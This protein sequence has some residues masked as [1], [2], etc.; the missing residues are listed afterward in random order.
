[1]IRLRSALLVAL[2]ALLAAPSARAELLWRTIN[3]QFPR[4]TYELRFALVLPDDFDPAKTHP[5]MLA[6]PP[7]RG[8]E[9]LVK[10][11]LFYWREGAER[12]GWVVVSPMWVN[13]RP[14]YEQG[15]VV[16]PALV[17]W[18][19]DTFRVEGGKP[20]LTGVSLG[21]VAAFIAAVEYTDLFASLTV[22]PGGLPREHADKVENLARLPTTFY[23]GERDE[24]YMPAAEQLEQAYNAMG[25]VFEKIVIPGHAH[26][27]RTLEDG[28]R[29]YANLDKRRIGRREIPEEIAAASETLTRLHN[30]AAEADE[31]TYFSLFSPA[32]VFL[33]S[34]PAERW[35]I[36][37]LRAFAEPYFER[38]SAWVY[39]AL[40][41]DIRLF[42]ENAAVF[43]ET[44]THE[45]YGLCRGTGVL[46]RI[47][48]EWKIDQ[49]S[50]SIPI[51]NELVDEVIQPIR[52]K[53][54]TVEDPR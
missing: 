16:L 35:T 34:D 45:K 13:E 44:L 49:Y 17:E 14:Y 33:G 31:Q 3:V 11:G 36:D 4:A 12:S 38:D 22:L 43:D 42:G 39:H 46:R 8:D 53:A 19:Q 26:V 24:Q 30:A 2:L 32:A 6:I 37:E 29:L 10:R 41:R 54:M 20:H 52:E 23:V 50:L 1:M 28:E 25:G 15:H 5:V 18:I 27:L 48:G 21:G 7:G 40:R 9:M 51:P 47:R